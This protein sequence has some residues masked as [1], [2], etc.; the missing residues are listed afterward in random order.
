MCRLSEMATR[1]KEGEKIIQKKKKSPKSPPITAEG[2]RDLRPSTST[3]GQ[4]LPKPFRKRWGRSQKES[5][6]SSSQTT[7]TAELPHQQTYSGS[8]FYTP[9]K[10][11]QHLIG[12]EEVYHD[13]QHAAKVQYRARHV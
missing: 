10:R 1:G 13:D 12:E 11:S 7:M 5:H 3:K 8:L 9:V 4:P 6:N 2:S